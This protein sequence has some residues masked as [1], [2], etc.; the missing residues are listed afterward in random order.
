MAHDHLSGK[1]IKGRFDP[2]FLFVKI[3]ALPPRD[4]DLARRD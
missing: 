2:I 1:E 3:N 4:E